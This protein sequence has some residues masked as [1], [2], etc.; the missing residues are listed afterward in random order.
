MPHQTFSDSFQQEIEAKNQALQD[1]N[2]H[3]PSGRCEIPFPYHVFP[4]ELQEMIGLYKNHRDYSKVGLAMSALTAFSVALGNHYEVVLFNGW[5]SKGLLYCA[6]V[7]NSSEGKTPT[8]NFMLKPLYELESEFE[9]DYIEE[10]KAYIKQRAKAA[11]ANE[12]FDEPEPIKREIILNDTTMEA[13]IQTHKKNPK[14]LLLFRDELLGWINSL[15]GYR[16]GKG[17]DQQNWLSIWANSRIKT[18]RKEMSSTLEKAY[19]SVFGGIQPRLL[20]EL[21]S[22]SK[23]H[24]G[25]LYRMLFAFMEES[26]PKTW[27]ELKQPI[28]PHTYDK[29]SKILQ[30]L[31]E[32]I[33]PNNS[34]P[35][36]YTYEQE[37]EKNWFDWHYSLQ[38]KIKE[39]NAI[40]EDEKA[41]ICS[42]MSLYST[43]FALILQVMHD[44]YAGDTENRVIGV[45]MVEKALDL[46]AYFQKTSE[47]AL[48]KIAEQQEQAS[49][50]KTRNSSAKINWN[51]LF[52]E[53]L[54]MST[55][56]LLVALQSKGL[57]RRSAERC[58]K[59]DLSQIKRGFYTK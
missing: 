38:V 57:S 58:I 45:G 24:D 44:Q 47:C 4:D 49:D 7:G 29:Y 22:G 51:E 42:K 43:R 41:S 54:E 14:G 31:A 11:E 19:V 18:T 59:Q 55:K 37:A 26:E 1:A 13:L 10:I 12:K 25:F 46:T 27:E 39:L 28:S 52:G 5:T 6:L 20:H 9:V 50:E 8:I 2:P 35:Y 17:A 3:L 34:P 36:Q 23:Q 32:H 30:S 33:L 16:A 53:K 15:N 40:G 21:A 56:E 48:L